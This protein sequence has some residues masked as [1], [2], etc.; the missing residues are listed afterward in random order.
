MGK[1]LKKANFQHRVFSRLCVCVCVC[2]SGVGVGGGGGRVTRVNMV[3]V[4]KPVFRNLP[5][6]YTWPLKKQSHSYT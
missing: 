6:S 1:R 4:R 2:V 5:H 3:R